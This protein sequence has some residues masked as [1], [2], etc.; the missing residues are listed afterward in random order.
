[1]ARGRLS[2]GGQLDAIALVEI[3]EAALLAQELMALGDEVE[4]LPIVEAGVVVHLVDQLFAAVGTAIDALAI[5]VYPSKHA[6]FV[7]V[8]IYSR[9]CDLGS[10]TTLERSLRSK[11]ELKHVIFTGD[12]NAHHSLWGSSQACKYGEDV[13]TW[14]DDSNL[15]LLNDGAATRFDA[16]S[17]TCIDLTIVSVKMASVASWEVLDD[18]FGSDHFPQLV[19][20]HNVNKGGSGSSEACRPAFKYDKA[21]WAKFRELCLGL[22]L[23]DFDSDCPELLNER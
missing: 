20:L 16:R 2:P 5:A 13:C 6:P 1:M 9:G 18:N 19:T 4:E 3:L 23:S 12:F 10:L 17:F 7:L 22:S 8:N 14:L 11:T 15:V 21:D